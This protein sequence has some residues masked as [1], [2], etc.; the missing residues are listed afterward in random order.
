MPEHSLREI[1]LENYLMHLWGTASFLD[2]DK[3]FLHAL[4]RMIYRC[5]TFHFQCIQGY[6]CSYKTPECYYRKHWHHSYGR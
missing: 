5:M 1:G 4:G 6:M 3:M 2:L